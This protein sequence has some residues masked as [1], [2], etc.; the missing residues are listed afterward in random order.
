MNITIAKILKHDFSKGSLNLFDS[1]GNAIYY[2]TSDGD[3]ADNRPKPN[4]NGKTVTI[5]GVEYELKEV[6]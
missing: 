4:C 3:I 1:N 6:D 2:E 5:D